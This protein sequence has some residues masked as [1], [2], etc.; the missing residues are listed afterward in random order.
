M[1]LSDRALPP[2]TH[3]PEMPSVGHYANHAKALWCPRTGL[4]LPT[5]GPAN[6]SQRSPEGVTLHRSLPKASLRAVSASL[7]LLTGLLA[8]EPGGAIAGSPAS[9]LKLVKS[10]DHVTLERFRGEPVY[11]EL[12]LFLASPDEPFELLV[13]RPDYSQPIQ[14]QRVDYSGGTPD[15]IDLPGDILNSWT[16]LSDFIEIEVKNS[17]GEVV[18]SST[19]PFCPNSY[20]RERIGDAGP[21]SPTYPESCY[22]NP[23]T[24]GMYWGIDADW[25]VGALGYDSPP[26]YLRNANYTVTVSIAQQYIDLFGVDP[27]AATASVDVTVQKLDYDCPEC[28][29]KGRRAADHAKPT[30]VPNDDDPDPALLP[31]LM[32][33]PAWGIGIDHRAKRQYLTFGATVW[34]GGAASLA[35]EGYRRSDEDVMDAYQYFYENGQPVGKSQV[36]TMEFDTRSGHQHWHF[37]QFARYSLLDSTQTELIRSKKEAF[38]LAP[39]DAIDLTVP[40][41]VRAPSSVGLG[42]AC[43]AATSLWVREILP[44][45]W[46]DTY[47]QYRPGQSFNIT[48]LENGTYYIEV[49]ANPAGSLFEQ[50][51]ANNTELR[52]IRL[53]GKDD[54]RRVVVPLWNGI[55]TEGYG[56]GK[57]GF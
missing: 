53:K 3:V 27:S 54:N 55:D 33:L 37:L 39:T 45:G 22:S 4:S 35:V 20:T 57:G 52:E 26:L 12:G 34:N 44:L 30:S 40:N 43:G 6:H 48:N 5:K 21:Q 17:K 13:T 31:D 2:S 15:V 49:T 23:F 42:S 36:G 16:G 41:A 50:T 38:C 32:G 51:D 7:I 8:I 29:G 18:T 25:A 56:G 46:G 10:A 19:S 11:L 14:I 24:R 28:P 1:M 9:T 47:S